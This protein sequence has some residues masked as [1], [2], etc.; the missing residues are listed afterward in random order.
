M[1]RVT[2]RCERGCPHFATREVDGVPLCDYHALLE[3][4][5]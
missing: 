5:R 4:D 1:A 2:G 3:V